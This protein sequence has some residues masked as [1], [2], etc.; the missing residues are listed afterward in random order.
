[1][2]EFTDEKFNVW[3]SENFLNKDKADVILGK[4]SSLNWKIKDKNNARENIIFGEQGLVYSSVYKNKIA[5]DPC[6]CWDNEK[7][8]LS[9]KK[10]IEHTTNTKFNFC[11]VMRYA[12]GESVIKTPGQRN[13]R[14]YKN[15]RVSVGI[16]RQ[17]K[18]S[19]PNTFFV[20]LL[21]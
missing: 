17:I 5:R 20:N 21:C 2:L 19:P 18:F 9:L 7:W 1:M 16:V 15:M 14:W 6:R 10:R 12:S 8:L 13:G 11:S 3:F 4:C